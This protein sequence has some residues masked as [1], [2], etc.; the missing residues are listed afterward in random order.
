MLSRLSDSDRFVMMADGTLDEVQQSKKKLSYSADY[1]TKALQCA[2]A[3]SLLEVWKDPR[4]VFAPAQIVHPVSSLAG[5]VI[6]SLDDAS[7]PSTSS[8]ENNGSG[9]RGQWDIFSR[10][11]RSRLSQGDGDNGEEAASSAQA[12]FEPSEETI[13]QLTDMGFSRE[14]ALD[15]LE[16]TRTNRIDVAMEFV[17]TIAHLSQAELAARRASREERARLAANAQENA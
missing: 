14:H 6:S 8:S 16:S 1:F 4:F 9:G 2:I 11:A 15:A 10:S 13:S 12:S 17:L 7:K 5:E 3:E